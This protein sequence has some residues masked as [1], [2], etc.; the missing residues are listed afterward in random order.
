LSNIL[1]MFFPMAWL[2]EL[3]TYT[4]RTFSSAIQAHSSFR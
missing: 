2:W 4:A 1:G 3:S